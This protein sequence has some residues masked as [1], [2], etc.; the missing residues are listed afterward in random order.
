M[1]HLVLTNTLPVSGVNNLEKKMRKKMIEVSAKA[2]KV[3]KEV[4]E[5]ECLL[6]LIRRYSYE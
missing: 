1:L 2:P 5:R 4:A 3:G 6:L